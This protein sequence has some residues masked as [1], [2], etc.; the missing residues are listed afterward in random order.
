M[1][2]SIF[3]PQPKFTKR[4]TSHVEKNSRAQLRGQALAISGVKYLS[5]TALVQD[6]ENQRAVRNQL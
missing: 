4:S 6:I 1:G 5:V 2:N 3:V